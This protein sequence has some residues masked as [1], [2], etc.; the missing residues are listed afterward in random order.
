MLRQTTLI[1]YLLVPCRAQSQTAEASGW[2]RTRVIRRVDRLI[3]GSDL[4][5]ST[6]LPGTSGPTWKSHLNGRRRHRYRSENNLAH[7][8]H[9]D[10]VL[11]WT[12]QTSRPEKSG[13]C[14]RRGRIASASF[15]A[16]EQ[17]KAIIR[18]D[19]PHLQSAPST[20]RAERAG[21]R[22][23]TPFTTHNTLFYLF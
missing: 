2:C 22:S 3:G 9:G 8:H 14:R 23:P 20:G 6:L 4:C 7:Q 19:R 18:V 21:S 13:R 16:P 5:C 12:G 17:P 11:T 10:H 15:R 1:A